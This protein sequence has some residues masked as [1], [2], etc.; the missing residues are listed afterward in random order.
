MSLGSSA[1]AALLRSD[2]EQPLFRFAIAQ[3]QALPLWPPQD[4]SV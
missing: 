4:V 2:P 3:G 1:I